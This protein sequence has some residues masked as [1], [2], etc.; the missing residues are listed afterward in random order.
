MLF[1]TF[2]LP[3]FPSS[4][5]GLRDLEGLWSRAFVQG[6]DAFNNLKR[7]TVDN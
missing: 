1:T 6:L 7:N 5:V 2:L 4:F 3:F